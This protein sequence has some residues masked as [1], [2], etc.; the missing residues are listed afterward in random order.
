LKCKGHCTTFKDE[1]YTGIVGL[2]DSIYSLAQK[3]GGKAAGSYY[4]N[5]LSAGQALFA[6][7]DKDLKQQN[8]D[9]IS[10]KQKVV[11]ALVDAQVKS[12]T[13]LQ[14]SAAKAVQDLRDFETQV[15]VDQEAL[16][17][18][19]KI[20]TEKLSG[21]NGDIAKL[22]QLITTNKTELSEDRTEYEQDITIAATAASYAWV[23]P[24]GTVIAAVIIGVYADKAIDMKAKIDGLNAVIQDENDQV[25][26]DKQLV[27]GLTLIQTDLQSLLDKIGP[28]ITAIEGMKGAW[29]AIA[30]DL[31]DIKKAVA[32]GSAED[33]PDLQEITQESILG[34]WNDL[35]EEVD[36]FR[37]S[38][39]ISPPEQLTLDEYSKQ[40]Q[41]VIDSRH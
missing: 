39:Y 30:S 8:Q 4:A 38:A 9:L 32:E 22:Q 24:V 23:F 27:A 12:I 20:I 18:R 16:K 13:A 6:E 25:S 33:L 19:N 35:K 3:A 40:L 17:S 36:D 26:A 15:K 11:N 10:K 14:T 5:I 34:Q 37:K 7:L 29:E 1:T 31:L 21:E 2:A 28:A 41:A